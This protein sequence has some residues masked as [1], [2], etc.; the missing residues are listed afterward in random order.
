MSVVELRPWG[1]YQVL[2]EGEGYKVK[3]VTVHP[4]HRLSLQ[5]HHRRSEHW[6]I[7]SGEA[8]VTR[9]AERIRLHPNES[10]HIPRGSR[11]RIGNC[12]TTLLV[13]IEVQCGDY[14]EEDDI[15]RLQDDYHRMK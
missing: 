1:S 7:V 13:F 10:V 15:V 12:G 11:H 2:A 8:E 9:D 3:R 4:A 6:V 14:L 5:Y